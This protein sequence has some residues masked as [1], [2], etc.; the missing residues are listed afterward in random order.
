MAFS[1]EATT[2][3]S[4]VAE[5]DAWPPVIRKLRQMHKRA[6]LAGALVQSDRNS[7]Q[8]AKAVTSGQSDQEAAEA[9]DSRF[10]PRVKTAE[11]ADCRKHGRA[12]PP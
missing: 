3:F 12:V 9:S 11:K 4:G 7:G 8:F 5:F 10:M 6:Q 1:F 2:R